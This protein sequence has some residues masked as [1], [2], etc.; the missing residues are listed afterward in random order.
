MDTVARFGGDEFIFL[1]EGL[2]GTAEAVTMPSACARWR[3]SP[4][5]IGGR[6]EPAVVSIGVATA[7]MR[8]LHPKS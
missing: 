6:S 1:F 8:R 2:T 5:N 4:S 7:V 3:I